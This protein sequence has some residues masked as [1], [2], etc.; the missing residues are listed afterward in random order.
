MVR[1]AFDAKQAPQQAV[2]HST[3]RSLLLATAYYQTS[4][5]WLKLGST[6]ALNRSHMQGGSPEQDK[7]SSALLHGTTAPGT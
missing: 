3:L 2:V 5:P 1:G 6:N 7:R 4:S